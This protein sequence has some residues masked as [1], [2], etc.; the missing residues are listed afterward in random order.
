MVCSARHLARVTLPALGLLLAAAC[1]DTTGTDRAGA[2]TLR[3]VPVLPDALA[4]GQ[5]N[6]AVDRVAIRLVRPPAEAVIDTLVFFPPGENQISVQLKVPLA[7][8]SEQ[9]RVT[10]ELH[11]GTT[12]LFAG[13]DTVTVTEARSTAPPI[14]LQYV[15]PGA[16][17]TRLRIAPRDTAVRPGTVFTFGISAHQGETPVPDFYVSWSTSDPA[18]APV[19]A[20]GTL[21]SPDQRGSIMLRVVSPTGIKD[22]TLVSF[23]P[24]AATF[25]VT[26]G[27]GQT[28]I[29]GLQLP[30]LLTVQARAADGLGVP[31]VR[32]TF[33]ALSGGQVLNP[34]AITD[35]NGFARTPAILGPTAGLQAFEATMPGLPPVAFQ[36]RAEVGPPTQ[37]QVLAGNGQVDTV[38][39]TLATPLIAR[40]ADFGGNPV[41]GVTVFWT[42]ISGG[43]TLDRASS[44]S[45][46]S[47][48]AFADL[49]LGTT[50]G[51]NV[52][53]A[54]M[55]SP[56]VSVD[57][58]A[59][60]VAGAPAS[61][62]ILAGNGQSAT[63]GAILPLPFSVSAADSYGNLLGGIT[64]RWSEVQGGG[65]LNPLLSTTDVLGRATSRYTLP[66]TPGFY[67]VVADIPGTTLSTVFTAEAK[68]PPPPP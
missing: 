15:G 30:G 24:P 44:V 33:R 6:L 36:A 57:F 14:A 22:S 37:L 51:P 2:A 50:P 16:N 7:A 34:D 13:T 9:L 58:T 43:G 20:V 10:L 62:V 5:F 63:A 18:L 26:G 48:I 61:L 67:N 39:H 17:L 41:A 11:S 27:D 65:S 68:A 28:G 25:T 3:L 46:L 66:S 40:V 52:V 42:V 55:A 29:A 54:T 45:N 32:V 64:V 31:G 38:G 23:S 53:R 47:G 1:G 19:N 35:A 21:T 59:T 60:A 49:T 8:R 56:A 4:E 12:L